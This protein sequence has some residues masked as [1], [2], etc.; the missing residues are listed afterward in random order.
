MNDYNNSI[1]FAVFIWDDVKPMN[2][3]FL[4]YMLITNPTINKMY[5]EDG[6]FLLQGI[7]EERRNS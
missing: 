3:N 5:Q 6:Q 4:Q 2:E 1:D 7:Y